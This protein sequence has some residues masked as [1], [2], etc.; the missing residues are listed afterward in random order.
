MNPQSSIEFWFDF[1]S[2][3]CYPA[4]MRVESLAQQ[5]N[6]E[7]QWRPFLLGPVFKAI[8]WQGLP[9]FVHEAKGRYVWRDM[10][11]RCQRQGLTFIKP[12]QFPRRAVLPL[13]IATVGVGQP[14]MGEFCRRVM[15]AEF[16]H[17]REIDREDEMRAV[18]QD[19]NL[20]ADDLLAAAITDANKQALRTRTEEAVARGI[21]GAPTIFVG[22]EMF[23]GDDR[24]ED[25]LEWAAHADD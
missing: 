14:W 1:S 4:V 3:Y 23:W 21:F 13:R 6:I 18:L 24:L 19:L 11:R 12:S 17:D 7:V 5:Q 15:L 25:A 22:E 20:P 2:N 10:E 16:A 8:G 9:L